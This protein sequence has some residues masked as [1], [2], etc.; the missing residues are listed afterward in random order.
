MFQAVV[1]ELQILGA[2]LQEALR[3]ANE[4]SFIHSSGTAKE[5][6]AQAWEEELDGLARIQ[7]GRDYDNA[8]ELLLDGE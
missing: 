3:L 1:R 8:Q 5:I 2:S 6:A 4:I 7:E